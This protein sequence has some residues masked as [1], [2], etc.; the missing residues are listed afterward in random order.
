MKKFNSELESINYFINFLQRKGYS[1]VKK[2]E[3]RYSYFD[4][5]AEKNG[6]IYKF[7]LKNRNLK[8]TTYNDTVMEEYK[9]NKFIENNDNGYLVTFFEDCFS[10]SNVR[11]FQSKIQK[12]ANKI[13][14]S[15]VSKTTDF[16]NDQKVIKNFVV[17]NQD[18]KYEYE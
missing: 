15:T 13:T 17:Y 1:E 9:Y 2:A 4:I 7:E 6:K 18:R 5:S 8:S 14:D 10:V 12:L 3:D 16:I 11:T